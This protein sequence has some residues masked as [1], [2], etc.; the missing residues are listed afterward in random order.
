[1]DKDK[2]QIYLA[3]LMHGVGIFYKRA[4]PN[5]ECS[6]DIASGLIDQRFNN[7]K[8]ID[9]H[10]KK[11][12]FSGLANLFSRN[13][14]KDMA[15]CL[16]DL[17][18]MDIDADNTLK[19]W[20]DLI[21]LS[22]SLSL[23]ISLED[24]NRIASERDDSKLLL[25]PITENVNI[26][27][28]KREISRWNTPLAK[29]SIEKDNF[30][31][32]YTDDV[33]LWKDNF[34]KQYTD[35]VSLWKE[36]DVEFQKLNTTNIRVFSES[37]LNLLFQY[38]IN[39]PAN[40]QYANDVS[41]YDHIKITAAIAVC[42]YDSKMEQNSN[43]QQPFLL[44]GAD[45]S[46]IQ[47]Y[48]YN[49][50][51]A[52]AA[53]SLKGRSF[54]LRLLTDS[55]VHYL[56]K[57]L[58]LPVANIIYNS[59]GGFYLLV[60]NTKNAKENLNK[61]V[62]D[63]ESAMFSQHGATL[64]LAMDSIELSKQALMHCDKQYLGDVWA[65]LFDKR[66]QKKRAKCLDT[67]QKLFTPTMPGIGGKR[68]VATGEYFKVKEEAKRYN[69]I[70][71]IREI[72]KKQIELGEALQDFY[73][74]VATE[75]DLNL[76][77]NK[78]KCIKPISLEES[79]YFYFIKKGGKA[80]IERILKENAC[81]AT[82]I[83]VN[84][85]VNCD[86]NIQSDNVNTDDNIK[87]F[88]FYG[89]MN[90]SCN[91]FSD[92]C[93]GESGENG[94]RRLG[95]L[96]MDVDNLGNIFQQGIPQEKCTLPR[97]AALSRSLDYFFSGYLNTLWEKVDSNKE[98]SRIIY[99]GGDDLFIL[100]DWQTMIKFAD[101][102]HSEFRNYTC[103]N[104]SF[105]ISGGIALVRDNFPI[106]K[107]AELSAEEE[108]NAKSHQCKDKLKNSISF[109]GMAMNFACEYPKIK[110]LKDEVVEA[111]N[112]GLP[113]SFLQKVLRYWEN[114]KWGNHKIGNPQTYW[115]LTYDLGRM[116]E[117]L[118]KDAKCLVDDCITQV[119]SNSIKDF[120]T[121]YHPLE[122]WAMACRWA[123]MQLRTENTANNDHQ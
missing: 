100:G 34:P 54:Y 10:E 15:S 35:Y 122:I 4:Y 48:I 118:G 36:F 81:L 21:R 82:F 2:E 103:H 49:I 50:T 85:D 94:F 98:T 25:T 88:S 73:L 107:A 65:M 67:L 31:K 33:S 57:K 12:F 42:L 43:E 29:L 119:C 8:D 11:S 14:K 102:I 92:L 18:R 115:M 58:N 71:P 111:V 7:F 117:R 113:H 5:N 47:P 91:D 27:N 121:D 51:S 9:S 114:A 37:L 1:M 90:A 74:I 95:V 62:K 104:S 28:E 22:E 80:E 75:S 61:A 66:D 44:V 109:L 79:L 17:T 96:R 52:H 32:Q 69:N 105:S 68:D 106:S 116:K 53:V 99:S 24:F 30:P 59:G 70:Y 20:H 108:S 26:N 110:G 64:F 101:E 97:M 55:V 45:L 3:A 123:E 19:D 93:K 84:Y 86:G 40:A 72:T 76:D 46:G 60:P 23:G 16:Q 83:S 41:L 6:E 77:E 120:A 112:K 56:L 39:I 78:F 63:V 38:A 89:G 87:S 13:K